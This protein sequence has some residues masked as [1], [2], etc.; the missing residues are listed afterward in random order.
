MMHRTHLASFIAVWLF[1]SLLVFPQEKKPIRE[2]ALDRYIVE[3]LRR[4][5]ATP[6]SPGS[7][8]VP[9][10]PL[11]NLTG[12]FRAAGVDDIVTILITESATASAKGSVSSGR[13][14]ALSLGAETASGTSSRLPWGAKAGVSK[15]SSLDGNG[16]T[17]R[18]T[19]FRT[20]LGARVTHVL[21]NGNL[22]IS[23]HKE[24]TINSER[25][26]VSIRGIVRPPDIAFGNFVRS[27]QIAEMEVQINGKGVVADAV[28]RPSILYRILMGILPF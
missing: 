5:A 28:R 24:V 19:Q 16:G 6:S 22:V 14:S 25:Q 23:G 11:L 12:D 10:S 26:I 3:S 9:S 15:Q 2:S 8:H 21:P 13:N 1:G 18:S 4:G 20:T 27:D 17:S 7:L